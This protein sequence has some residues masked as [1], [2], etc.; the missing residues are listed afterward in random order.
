MRTPVQIT[1]RHVPQSEALEEKIRDKMDKLA[2]LYP[3]ILDGDATVDRV[4]RHQQQGRHFRI[5]LGVRIP[6]EELIVNT[7]HEDAFIALRNAVAAMRLQLGKAIGKRR[8]D[9]RSP[10]AAGS[11]AE[12]ESA[13]PA[14]EETP[15]A[16][17]DTTTDGTQDVIPFMEEEEAVALFSGAGRRVDPE[18]VAEDVEKY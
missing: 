13:P 11:Q 4:A 3:E 12:D 1:F 18:R 15:D 14:D 6:G 2:S 16:G 10:A 5:A 17:V 8:F 9:A 7:N